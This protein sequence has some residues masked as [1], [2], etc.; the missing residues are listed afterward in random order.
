MNERLTLLQTAEPYI[1][2]YYSQ[3]YVRRKILRQTDIEI[4]EQDKLIEKEIK[5]GKYTDPKLMPAIGP[6]GNPLEPMAANN[7]T[8][9]STPKEP[10][11]SNA[12]KAT[13][14]NAKG[15]EI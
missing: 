9:G 5:D 1:G 13:S 3:D 15:A 4:I 12:D 6:D 2:K 10:D 7:E 8:L 11:I 14:V